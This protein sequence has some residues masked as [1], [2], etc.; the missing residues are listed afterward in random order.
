MGKEHKQTTLR[1]MAVGLF[2]P[3]PP[4]KKTYA[5][6]VSKFNETREELK[7][8]VDDSEVDIMKINEEIAELERA[9]V[10]VSEEK[11]SALMTLD[12]LDK[13]VKG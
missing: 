3:A 9:K 11:S 13:F 6:I 10:T 8:L 1:D 5:Q 4:A 2:T 7:E 12:F